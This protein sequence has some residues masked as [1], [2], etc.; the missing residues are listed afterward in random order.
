VAISVGVTGWLSAQ[1][2]QLLLLWV[3]IFGPGAAI[4]FVRLL[5]SVSA[6]STAPDP[7]ADGG[8]MGS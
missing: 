4:A 5:A 2:T 3:M 1:D 8:S 7:P 6:G